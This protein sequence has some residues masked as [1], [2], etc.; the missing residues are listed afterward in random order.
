M[1]ISLDGM[2]AAAVKRI[3]SENKSYNI[4]DSYFR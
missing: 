4:Q 1:S 2:Q 3:V